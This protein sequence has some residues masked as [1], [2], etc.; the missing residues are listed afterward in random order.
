VKRSWLIR[1]IL[2]LSISLLACQVTMR[3]PGWIIPV[4]TPTATYEA[5]AKWLPAQRKTS[6][7]TSTLTPTPLPPTPT[8]PPTATPSATPT[9]EI[10]ANATPLPQSVQLNI[11]NDLWMTINEDYLY[12]DF[13]GLDWT[14]I[15]IEYQ[16]RI[17]SGMTD[18]EFYD[19]MDEVV[20]RLGDDHSVFLRPA[21]VSEEDEEFQGKYDY[22]GIGVMLSAVPD[23]QRAVVLVTFPG[24]P[25][26]TAGLQP[27]DNLLA[28][29][30]E[31]ILDEEGFLRDIVRGPAGSEV[32]LTVQTPGQAPRQVTLNR[33]QVTYSLPVPYQILK[34]PEG[35]R[36]GYILLTSFAENG[37]DQ[38]VG[39]AMKAM[40]EEGKLD[41]LII[42]NTQNGG[43]VDTILRP[44]LAYF[45]EGILGYFVS[46]DSK[47]PFD[48]GD[49]VDI[50]GSQQVPLVVLVG[51]DTASYG[52]VFAGVLK[53]I[54]R[55]C[56][57]GETTDGNVETLWAYAFEDGSRAWIAHA[58]FR[59]LK[60]PDQDW[61][62]T[63]IIPDQTVLA[64]W[65]EYT[66][67]DDPLVL[68]ALD[69]FD[70]P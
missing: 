48:V 2:L 49:G 1:T 62:V 6:T 10:T 39:E 37:I 69:H 17:E 36:I 29:N 9:Q 52:E 13:N 11:F 60:H 16:Q 41:G 27:R 47:R 68:A 31:P 59:P 64:H 70:N 65:D 8:P 54:G 50:N 20:M 32:T 5:R 51:L 22:V 26:E 18:D 63:G 66:A 57:I 42:D 45:T 44:T 43:G 30:G 14:E 15:R 21:Q 33:Q 19:A 28:V 67:A 4:P 3:A 46:R 23:R 7:P 24:S 38:K 35:K 40:T 58:S 34:S 12:E 25:A 53:D 56:I 55:A 61:E